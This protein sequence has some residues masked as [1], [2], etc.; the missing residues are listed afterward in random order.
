MI[1]SHKLKKRDR[2]LN[3]LKAQYNAHEM[4]ENKKYAM[5]A[6]KRELSAQERTILEFIAEN[7]DTKVNFGSQVRE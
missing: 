7:E 4:R 6:L 1:E 2:Y 5:S 3:K